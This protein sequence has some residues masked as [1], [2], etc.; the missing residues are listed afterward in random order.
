[1][2]NIFTDAIRPDTFLD[3]YMAYNAE[4]ETPQAYDFMCG[5]WL[6][7]TAI[8]RRIRIERP[9]APVWMNLYIILCAESGTTRKST[10]VRRAEEVYNASEYQHE[11]LTVTGSA[12][13][14]SLTK[15][16]GRQSANA[17]S[18]QAC[19]VVSEL[20][21]L[22][23]RERYS[24]GVPGLLTD[25]YDCPTRR[26]IR[27]ASA[28]PV[29]IDRAFINLLSASTPSWLVR[30]I[31][32]DVIEGGFTSRC[33]FVVEEQRK[34]RIAWPNIAVSE[35]AQLR[36]LVSDLRN[37]RELAERHAKR[38]ITMHEAAIRR[39]V[40]WYEHR[41]SDS[42]DA[43]SV[44]F[45]AREDHHVLRLAGLL[46]ANDGSWMINV[47]HLTHATRII[48]HHKSR[49]AA[50]FGSGR[51]VQ[52]LVSGID[53]IRDVLASAGAV[54]LSQTDLLYKT[55]RLMAVREMDYLLALMH[56]LSM[57]QR[58]DVKTGGRTRI[59]WRGTDKLMVREINQ[60]LLDRLT[61][62]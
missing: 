37:V 2:A 54:G 31:N 5:L 29:T 11:Y 30:A 26:E 18:G 62:T 16:L 59:V 34:R 53:R 28:E 47:N 36:T 49:G 25:L 44:S 40:S 43:Y 13:A 6:L 22:L 15:D 46:A 60:L 35:A 39:F 45:E 27:R 14:E 20:V 33:L 32:P 12:T 42:S 7:S 1:M 8:G 3:R 57:V 9:R 17:G 61:Q 19:I 48:A 10:A 4:I 50:L 41:S 21:T 51:E 38:G 58:Y 23:G 56:E 55:R 52:R 24:M